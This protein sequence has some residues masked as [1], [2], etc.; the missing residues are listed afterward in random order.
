MKTPQ[1]MINNKQRVIIVCPNARHLILSIINKLEKM[2]IYYDYILENEQKI[3]DAPVIFI[4]NQY[5]SYKH[6]ILVLGNINNIDAEEIKSLAD[7]TPKAGTIIY[8]KQNKNH[9][10]FIK[11]FKKK[12]VQ[13]L[14]YTETTSNNI[15]D[16]SIESVLLE[17]FGVQASS[18]KN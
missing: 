1:K 10:A 18:I 2:N 11:S 7:K 17:R 13:I 15:K 8:N 4:E 6:H 12:D 3:T 16:K 14:S 5:N 9:V